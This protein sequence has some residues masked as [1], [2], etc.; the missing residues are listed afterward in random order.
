MRK[1]PLLPTAA[2]TSR[3]LALATS[4][5]LATGHAGVGATITTFDVPNSV[6]TAGLSIAADGSITGE[7]ADSTSGPAQGFVRAPDGTFT[8]FSPKGSYGTYPWSINRKG[9]VGGSYFDANSISHGFVRSAKGRITTFDPPGSVYTNVA[10]INDASSITGSYIDSNSV[11]HGFVRHSDGTVTSIDPT[12]SIGTDA[13]GIN[14]NGDIVGYY[15]LST[16]RR[17]TH[18]FLRTADGTITTFDVKPRGT[19]PIGI[20]DTDVISGV[21][22]KHR[23]EYGFVRASDGT[24]RTFLPAGALITTV[25]A[26][27]DKGM[28]IGSS[29]YLQSATTRGFV[30]SASGKITSFDGP[31][32]TYTEPYSINGKGVITGNFLDSSGFSHGFIRTP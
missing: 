31:T 32:A 22:R 16:R 18:G 19:Q 25:S 10:A 24:I 15:N 27:N 20:N 4:L 2:S 30:R 12:G 3:A 29:Y 1:F 6:D 26:I 17:R 7:F 28:V 14:T 11:R 23:T 8:T 9:V 5:L 21:C 13:E